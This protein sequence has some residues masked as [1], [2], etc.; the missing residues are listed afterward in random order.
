M[1]NRVWIKVGDLVLI[2]LRDFED[3]KGDVI[4]KYTPV[5]YRDLKK[6]GEL[7]ET[8]KLDD[9]GLDEEDD[10]VEFEEMQVEPQRKIMMP[11]SDD[12]EEEEK[13]EDLDI[14]NI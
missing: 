4:L 3:D 13:K 14:N 8:F 9:E 7:Q 12:D 2:S 5:E 11:D 1:K 10:D 6:N